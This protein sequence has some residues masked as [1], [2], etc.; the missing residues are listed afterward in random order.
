MK[1][2]LRRTLKGQI[3]ATVILTLMFSMITACGGDSGNND[4]GSASDT[5]NNPYGLSDFELR[6]S[7]GTGSG[8]GRR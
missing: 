1:T 2:E 4:K 3:I 7:G 6:I 8:Q 5:K